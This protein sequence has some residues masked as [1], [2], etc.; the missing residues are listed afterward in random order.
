MTTKLAGGVIGYRIALTLE[1]NYASAMGDVVMGGPGDFQCVLCDGSLPALGNVIMTNVKRGTGALAGTY[2][3]PN[4]P[5][6]VS[7]GARGHAVQTFTSG[8]AITVGTTVGVKTDKKLY[9]PGAGVAN[10]GIALNGA[11]GTGTAIDVLVQ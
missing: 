2:P 9:P 3:Q 10:I 1:A 11:A 4:T 8:A 6:D 7:V 5:G